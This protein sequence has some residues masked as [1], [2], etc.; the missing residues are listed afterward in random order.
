MAHA[1][2]SGEGLQ[3]PSLGG[4]GSPSSSSAWPQSFRRSCSQGRAEELLLLPQ[5]ALKAPVGDKERL[6]AAEGSPPPGGRW[7]VLERKK[8][9]DPGVKRALSAVETV[10]G[11]GLAL[12][13]NQEGE[14]EGDRRARKIWPWDR[15]Q[16]APPTT[17][18]VSSKVTGPKSQIRSPGTPK[19]TGPQRQSALPTPVR[20]VAQGRVKAES[21]KP[22]PHRAR[23]K[24]RGWLGPDGLE[25]E[26]HGR[27]GTGQWRRP[28]LRS[29]A[30]PALPSS[31]MGPGQP[32]GHRA[33]RR[34]DAP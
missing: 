13:R 28:R 30:S 3:A 1:G 22:E 8:T 19:E 11:H 6:G 7:E 31:A 29:R 10:S 21:P 2:G 12:P 18:A 16:R 14:G 33:L 24:G 25:A 9:Q 15:R 20:R 34:P 5:T 23:G 26:G 4:L 32:A 17:G 27:G